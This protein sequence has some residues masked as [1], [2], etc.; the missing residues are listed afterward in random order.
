MIEIEQFTFNPFMENTYV[1]YDETKE[2]VIIDP[3]CYDPRE[4]KELL[5]FVVEKTLKVKYILNTHGHIDHVLGNY[6]A[7]TH[8]GVDLLIGKEDLQTLKSVEVYAANYGFQGYQA[9]E[10]DQLLDTT[11]IIK[12]G[13]SSLN[14][15]FVPGHAPGHI[16]FYPTDKSF[17][18]GGDVLF[19]GS[20]GRTDLPG[21]DFDTLINSIHTEFF[22][23]P[24]STVVHPGHGEATTIGEEKV[25]NPFCALK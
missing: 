10:P 12:F 23:F 20:I 24:D 13:N 7:K 11:D 16:A 15:L 4:H 19:Q 25:S 18:I 1:L 9:T 2:A 21:G 22:K 17:I 5:D 3:G 6:F 8:F 14:I